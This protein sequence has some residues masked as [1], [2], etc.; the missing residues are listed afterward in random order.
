MSI[1]EEITINNICSSFTLNEKL[2]RKTIKDS[3]PFI[4]Y[5]TNFSGGIIK[6]PDGCLLVFDSGKIVVTGDRNVTTAFTLI[7]RFC[8]IYPCDV[9]RTDFKIVNIVAH[10][11]LVDNFNYVKLKSF[12]FYSYEPELFPG[13]HVKLDKTKVIF[14]IFRTGRITVTGIRD[15]NLIV[16]YFKEF[17][18]VADSIKTI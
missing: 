4:R 15:T 9:Y 8:N 7:D 17:E 6:Y 5:P 11:R 2:C 12:P 16:R 13:I 18:R 10:S 3:F 14:I 1:C